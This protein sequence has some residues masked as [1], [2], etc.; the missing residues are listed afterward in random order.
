MGW[1]V[2]SVAKAMS[3]PSVLSATIESYGAKTQQ[4]TSSKP[5]PIEI[6]DGTF[7]KIM[8]IIRLNCVDSLMFFS[9]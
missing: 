3:A 8:I 5:N 7:N 1:Y 6:D 4:C 2:C 9:F